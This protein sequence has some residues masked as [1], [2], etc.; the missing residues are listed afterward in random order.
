MYLFLLIASFTS[1]VIIG[2]LLV[3]NGFKQKWPQRILWAS[4]G[5]SFAIL[6]ATA[7]LG[8]ITPEHKKATKSQTQELQATPLMGDKVRDPQDTDSGSTNNDQSQASQT[9][10]PDQST[11]TSGKIQPKAGS[12]TQ[13][14]TAQTGLK[15]PAQS[16]DQQ[17][18]DYTSSKPPAPLSPG[19]SGSS[20]TSTDTT[21]SKPPTQQNGEMPPPPPAPPPAPPAPPQ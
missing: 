10:P 16:G 6:T 12:T 21:P 20:N 2:V 19:T 15:T 14:S 11:T 5:I 1:V 7:V 4:M 3:Y 13:S 17:A 8:P 18:A 9:P